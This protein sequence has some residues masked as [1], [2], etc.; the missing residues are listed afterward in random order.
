M[1]VLEP[2]SEVLYSRDSD[3]FRKRQYGVFNWWR[4]RNLTAVVEE[5]RVVRTVT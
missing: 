3:N 5:V 4:V 2:G 1:E